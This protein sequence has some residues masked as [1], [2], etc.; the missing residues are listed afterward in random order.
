M[1]DAI[2]HECGVGLIRLLKPLKYYQEKYGSPLWGL[3]KMYL[4]ME[5]Q[6]NRGQDGAG[7]ASVKIQAP[8]GQPYLHRKRN[9]S[10]SPWQSLFNGIQEEMKALAQ[11]F[12]GI[13]KDPDLL[14]RHFGFSGELLLGHLRYGTHGDNAIESCH[15]VVRNNSWR[16][17]TLAVAGNFNL[18]NVD[19]LFQYL[20]DLGQHP[21]YLTDTETV[22]ERIGHFLDQENQALFDKYKAQG[23]NN[24]EISHL[25]A[26]NLDIRRIMQRAA[27]RWDGGY[28][29]GGVVGCGDGFVAR[30][31]HGIRP[32]Y[33]YICDEFV[34]VASERPA[35][36]TVFGIDYDEIMELEPGHV[37]TVKADGQVINK[38]FTEEKEKKSCSFERIYFSR[39]NDPDIYRE[40]LALG[41]LLVP[42]ILASVN[43][44]LENTVFGYIP[45]TAEMAF[46]GMIKGVETYMIAEKIR[47]LRELNGKATDAQMVE[48]L[49]TRPRVEKVVLKDIK[50]RTFITDDSTRDDLV[51]HVY[52]ITQGT[53]RPGKDTFVCIDDSI[54]RGTT[55]KKSILGI[56]AQ[57]KPKKIVIVSSGPQIRYPDCYGI[58]MSQIGR[59]IAFEAAIALLN[60][61][62]L[63]GIIHQVY[64]EC[65]AMKQ[66]GLLESRNAVKAI[67]DPFSEDEIS[68]KIS[69][70]LKPEG[71][72]CKVDIVFQ[73][74]ENLPKAIPNHRGDWYF[75][76]NYPTPGGN[77]VVNQAFINYIEGKSNRAY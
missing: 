41:D 64:R 37:I 62:G 34:V 12:P 26:E 53:I 45:N 50:L 57:L 69:D 55:L 32:A 61:R 58:D 44:D 4:L 70:L 14:H 6:H 65:L 25:I 56:L 23:K 54:V 43:H 5:K 59:F 16:S 2:K 8:A 36:A 48:V 60:D 74:L 71:I 33:H 28:T 24:F 49:S 72:S 40:R 22:M 63:Y 27:K 47:K 52:D 17:R 75:S 10:T 35:I 18:T 42:K 30:D 46:W 7:L 68:R 38:A 51:A 20:V 13:E 39:G 9:N 31:P 29:M 19:D 1:S 11:K 15:P 3:N 21:R 76:G 73:P 67:Y 77:R 66:A